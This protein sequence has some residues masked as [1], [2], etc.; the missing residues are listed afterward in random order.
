M[1]ILYLINYAGSGGSER[2]VE[3]LARYYHGS[4]AQ[5][6]LCYNVDGPL[7]EKMRAL[8]IP[9]YQLP[10]K[11]IADISA[12]KKL[13]KIVKDGGYD[14]IHA[15]YPRENYIAI[16][17]RMF[18]CKAKIVFTSHLISEQPPVWR[19]LNRIFTPHDHAVLTVCTYGKEVLE[20]GGVAKDK[21]RIVFNGVDAPSAP[22][23]DRSVLREFGIGDEETVITILTRFSEEKGVPFLLRSIARLKEQTSVPFRLLLVGTGPDFDRDKALIPELGIGDK[24]V[25]TGFRTDTA[26]LLAASDIYLNSSSSEAMSFAILEALGAGL[27]LVLTHVGG[28]PELVNTGE[29]CG[30]LAPYGDEDAYAGAIAKLLEDDA[31]R[32]R[33]AAAARA[34]AEG[35]FDLYTLLDKLFEIYK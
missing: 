26:R 5:C 22:V 14:V 12:A 27:P 21:I 17:S 11:S 4:K 19:M 25:L 35:E 33:Y 15:Q 13:A 16:L 32:A 3:L 34:K 20:R 18:G 2:Y 30:I 7:V 24:V 9:V 10:M 29:I 28:N 8:D 1:K 23:R 6:G 31:L